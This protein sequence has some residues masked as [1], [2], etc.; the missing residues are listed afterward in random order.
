MTVLDELARQL[1]TSGRSLR[2]A[3]AKG[4][5]RA[6]QISERRTLVDPAEER[7]IRFHWYLLAAMVAALRTQTNVRLAVLF[8]SVARGNERNSSDLDV[9]VEFAR[10]S[11]HAR[12]LVVERLEQATGRSVQLVELREAEGTP[13]L[14]ADVLRDG[15]VLVDR[16]GEWPRL[17]RRERTIEQRAAAADERLTA[18][19]AAGLD[20]LAALQS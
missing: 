1:G 16:D 10:P 4:A 19:T 20:E 8:G 18:E 11:I 13:L 9:L 12:S 5:I 3:A 17:K 6:R 14:L 2:R 7:Y 15:R